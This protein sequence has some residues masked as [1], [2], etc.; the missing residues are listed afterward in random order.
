MKLL[1]VIIVEI[2]TLIIDVCVSKRLFLLL[3]NIRLKIFQYFNCCL[4]LN[5]LSSQ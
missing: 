2:Y 1:I 4:P 5:I 3:F